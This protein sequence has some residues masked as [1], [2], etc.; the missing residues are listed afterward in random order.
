MPRKLRRTKK[1]ES[2]AVLIEFT[3][4][5]L[6]MFALIFLTIDTAW[7]IFGRACL[8]EAVREGVRFGVTGQLATGCSGLNCSIKKTVQTYSFGFVTS[9]NASSVVQIHYYSPAT[10]TEVTGA[11][12][13]IGGNVVQVSVQGLSLVPL[14]PLW[15]S[16]G[17]LTLNASSSDVME[18]GTNAAP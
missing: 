6:P 5:I 14:A 18:S 11:S 8:Q 4:V 9:S 17:A 13:S 12:A 3:F 15:R 2:G 7:L 10:L 16:S 1:R